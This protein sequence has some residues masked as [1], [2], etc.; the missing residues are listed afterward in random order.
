MPDEDTAEGVAK[1]NVAPASVQYVYVNPDVEPVVTD[2]VVKSTVNGLQTAAGFV[3]TTTGVAFTVTTTALMSKQPE[4]V[5]P[6]I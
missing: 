3:T 2:A 6:L 5:V 1:D 4:A